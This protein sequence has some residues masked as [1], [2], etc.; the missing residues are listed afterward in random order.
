MNRLKKEL[1]RHGIVFQNEGYD[2]PYEQEREF[3]AIKG[4]FIITLFYSNV[5]P[6][7][8]HLFNKKFHFVGSQNLYPERSLSRKGR[9]WNSE[10][11]Y[12]EGVFA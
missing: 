6:T 3:V 5:M 9:E 12:E 10:I 1:V 7:E 2:D 8:I 4:D 11:T